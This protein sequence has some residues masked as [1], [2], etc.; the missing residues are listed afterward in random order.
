MKKLLLAAAFLMFGA[1][2]SQAATI[3]VNANI[4][5]NTTWT[6][7]NV[8]LIDGYIFVQNN[9]TLTIQP[10]TL[11]KGL[12]ASKGCLIIDRG[13]QIYAVGTANEPIVFT[14]NEAAGNRAPGD[15]GGIILLGKAPSNNINYSTNPVTYP[16][17]EGGVG[18]QAYYGG[19]DPNDNSGTMKYVRIEF[20]GVAFQPNNEIN[21]LTF[22]AVGAGTTIDYIQVSY[23]GDDSYEWFGG[24]VNCK[25]LIAFR[26][27]DDDWDTDN[28][29]SGKVQF[30]VSLRHIS[31]ND[32]VSGSNG[33][34][35][36]NDANGSTRA[37][38]TKAVFTN[39]TVIGPGNTI[40]AASAANN[41]NFRRGHHI[42]RSSKLNVYNTI[43]MGFPFGILIDGANTYNYYTS[44]VDTNTNVKSEI[45]AGMGVANYKGASATDAQIQAQYTSAGDNNVTY[46][47]DAN[48]STEVNIFSDLRATSYRGPGIH[49]GAFI[50]IRTDVH[51]RGHKDYAF[52]D[53]RTVA[54]TCTG[55]YANV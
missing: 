22:G 34:E 3:T 41:S 13:A 14:S 47:T 31:Q 9:A 15:W 36:D 50:Y 54:C 28:G 51:V 1:A 52:G 5:T 21:G 48:T 32:P 30:G 2:A 18:P 27:T 11:I 45:L 10:G 38:F 49:H 29:F 24:S 55:D 19:T 4:T 6:K 17:I 44:G 43:V 7:N 35:S 25:H 46:N 12:K 42:R 16:V 26:G 53:E 39:M 20:P 37:P 40:A 8:Y 23:S 33:F